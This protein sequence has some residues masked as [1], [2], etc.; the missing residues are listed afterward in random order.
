MNDHW[1]LDVAVWDSPII[2]CPDRKFM[3]LLKSSSYESH[4]YR[5]QYPATPNYPVPIKPGIFKGTD[6]LSG[7]QFLVLSYEDENTVIGRKITVYNFVNIF[8][9]CKSL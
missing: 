7:I 6:G 1:D 3:S 9:I 5:I 2:D 8:G 4:L